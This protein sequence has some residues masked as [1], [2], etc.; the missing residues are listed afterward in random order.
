MTEKV[1]R[2]PRVTIIGTRGYPSHYGGLETA[3]RHLVPYLA[4]KGWEVTVWNRR[5]TPGDL[6]SLPP[7]V[8]CLTA[9]SV[10]VKS[11]SNL[12]SGLTSTVGTILHGSDVALVMNTAN[13]FWLPLLRAAR[14]PTLI[15]TDGLEWQRDKWGNLAKKVLYAGA[16]CT[17]KFGN[18]L[19]F[20]SQAI[21]EY[22]EK[23]FDRGGFYAPYG[24]DPIQNFSDMHGIPQGDY[25]LLVFRF[26][27]ENTVEEFFAAVPQIARKYPVVLVGSTGWNGQL[28]K[29]AQ[30]LSQKYKSVIWMGHVNDESLLNRLFAHCGLYFHGHSVGGTNPALVQAMTSGSAILA[31]DTVYSREVLGDCGEFVNPHSE[32]IAAAITALMDNPARRKYLGNAGFLRAKELFTWEKVCATYHEALRTTCWEK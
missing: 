14:I 15:N 21:R 2:R 7:H 32:E 26:V 28:D 27:P 23:E 10:E 6:K 4:D 30:K 16:W 11:L 24:G 17:A 5:D 22:W 20:D 19:L 12:S 29:Q 25:V 1:Q 9:P 18:H 13:G 8:S 31:R 3:V